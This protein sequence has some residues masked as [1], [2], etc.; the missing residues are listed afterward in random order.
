[1]NRK[2]S[3]KTDTR[4]LNLLNVLACLAVVTMHAHS[5]LYRFSATQSY[6]RSANAVVAVCYFAV[7]VF[8]MVTGATLLDYSD[9]YSTREFFQKRIR[10]TG[11]PYLVWSI[12]GVFF[13]AF[14]LGKV[15][16]S[17]RGG[18]YWYDA[19]VNTSVVS[20]YWFFTSLFCIYLTMPLLSAVS[21]EKRK[22][23]LT[24]LAV[25]GYVLNALLPFLN[26]LLELELTLPYTVYGVGGDVL[27]VVVGY[28]L[29]H[30]EISP[31]GRKVLYGASVAALLVLIFGSYR[32]SMDTGSVHRLF[33]D[34]AVSIPYAA[35]IVLFCKTHG[36]RIMDSFV[37]KIVNFLKDY[38]FAIYLLQWFVFSILKQLPFIDDTSLVYRL[39]AVPVV[40]AVCIG[41]TWVLR[42]IPGLRRIVP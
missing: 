10:K 17:T 8:F 2:V 40:V 34:R 7:P 39:G 27:F 38:T 24:Y 32:W 20:Y 11:I 29:T 36:A 12:L 28:L 31:R 18:R 21:K 9:R 19:I 25:A 1:M 22:A 41:I 33:K 14:V 23:V 13:S 15:E 30:Y 3:P 37:G 4:Y 5:C 35:G 16:L 42:K 26:A 6:W